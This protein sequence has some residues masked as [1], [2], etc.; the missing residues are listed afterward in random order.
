MLER[1][2]ARDSLGGVE[3][4]QLHQQVDRERVGPWV[5]GLE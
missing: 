2:L 1:L 4:E 3:R 5:Q